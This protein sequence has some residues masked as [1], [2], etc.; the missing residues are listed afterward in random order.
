M[1]FYIKV[2]NFFESRIFTAL[3]MLL[4]AVFVVFEVEE[5][6]LI[7]MLN[8]G[9]LVL[10]FS[11]NIANAYFPG[12]LGVTFLIKCYLDEKLWDIPKD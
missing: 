3:I 4:A 5:Y 7:V 10:L 6:G 9:A 2:R 8:I 1:E 12:F 11:E